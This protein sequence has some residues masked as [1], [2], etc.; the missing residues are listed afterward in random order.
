MRDGISSVDRPVAGLTPGRAASIGAATEPR[1]LHSFGW[2]GQTAELSQRVA[3]E[4][5]QALVEM[6][7][8]F[9]VP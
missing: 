7:Q 4:T 3:N 8:R 1:S 2:D 9:P 5:A 6:E